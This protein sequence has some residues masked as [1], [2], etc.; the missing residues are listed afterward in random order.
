[1]ATVRLRGKNWVLNWRDASGQQHRRIVGSEPHFTKS[2]AQ[3]ALRGIEYELASGN[4]ILGLNRKRDGSM[5]WSD[6]THRYLEWHEQQYPAGHWRIKLIAERHFARYFGNLQLSAIDMDLAEQY[7]ALRSKRVA[8]STVNKELQTLKA[9]LRKAVEWKLIIQNP[10]SG[11]RPQRDPRSSPI[12]FYSAK[13]LGV[14]YAHSSKRN[15]AI[16]KL[17][18]NTGMRR[19]EAL[20]LK[21]SDVND[22]AI[23]IVSSAH[24]RTKS[25]RWRHVPVSPG[26]RAALEA[27]RG[28]HGKFVL[29]RIIPH[30]LTRQFDRDA[31]RAGLNG[32]LHR[33][34]HTFASHLVTAGRPLYEVK[35]LLGHASITTTEIYA[36]LAPDHLQQ[37]VKGIDL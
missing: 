15:S 22:N 28:V 6:F 17:L 4:P 18:A 25:G 1:M 14:L 2:D 9:M 13:E 3:L 33:L 21:W 19:G 11:V 7:V 10:I 16:W 30:S 23:T 12:T 26:A 29:P 31:K 37:S 32:S 36:H 35:A 5:Q 24:A 20:N 8:P 27:L 34:R